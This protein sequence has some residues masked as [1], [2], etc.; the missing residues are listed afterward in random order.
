M[1]FLDSMIRLCEDGC[2]FGWHER[3]AGNLSYRLTD[4]EVEES[5]PCFHVD[6]SA[7]WQALSVTAE[8]LK[9]SFLAIS[10]AGRLLKNAKSLPRETLGIVEISESGDSYRIVWGL[11]GGHPTSELFTHV[12]AHEARMNATGGKARV[13]YHAHCPNVIA[14]SNILEP[15][16]RTWTKTL[17]KTMTE[18]ILFFPEGLGVVPWMVPGGK[19]IAIASKDALRTHAACVWM[20]HGLFATGE[21]C[22]AT[23]GLAH[24]IEKVS[25]IYLQGRSA[26][27]GAEPPYHVSGDQ[28]RLICVESG[29]VPNNEYL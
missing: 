25:G 29:V 11:E 20:Q 7:D 6:P 10:G 5:F 27:G 2:R 22:D 21:D 23:F 16:A 13:V 1:A 9:G 12:L 26:C 14:L 15:T 18:S 17:W 4:Q 8:S 28:L 24:M 3:N 19:E